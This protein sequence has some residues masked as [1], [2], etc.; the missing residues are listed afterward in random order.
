[1]PLLNPVPKLIPLLILHVTNCSLCIFVSQ[2]L[3]G[4]T[5]VPVEGP[6]A[7]LFALE[8]CVKFLAIIFLILALL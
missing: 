2:D 1:M 3:T 5:L 4:G 6:L 7:P 8:V